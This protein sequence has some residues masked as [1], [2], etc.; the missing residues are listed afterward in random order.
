VHFGEAKGTI[1]GV[2]SNPFFLL[3]GQTKKRAQQQLSSGHV[4]ITGWDEN[5]L[6]TATC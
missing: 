2:V 4:S 5:T 1:S 3:F 6:I